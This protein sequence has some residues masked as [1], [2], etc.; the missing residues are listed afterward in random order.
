MD[1]NL[2]SRQNALHWWRELSQLEKIAKAKEW[3]LSLSDDNTKK[4]WHIWLILASD[5]VIH[6]IYNHFHP[7]AVLADE[8]LEIYYEGI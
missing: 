6:T 3:Q 8:L 5:S 4:T 7:A 1:L 2:Q